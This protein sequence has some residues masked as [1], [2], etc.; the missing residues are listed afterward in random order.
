MSTEAL[1]LDDRQPAISRAPIAREIEENLTS[2]LGLDPGAAIDPDK[3]FSAMGLDSLLAID[4]I[5]VLETRHGALPDTVLR[6]NPTVNRLTD[7][8]SRLAAR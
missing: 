1:Q 7:Y 5:T 6:D 2:L 8:L 4:L 3:R